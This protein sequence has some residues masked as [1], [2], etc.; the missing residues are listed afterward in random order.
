MPCSTSLSIANRRTDL[1][2]GAIA[3]LKAFVANER[4]LQRMQLIAFRQTFDGRDFTAVVNH[5]QRQTGVDTPAVDEHGAGATLTVIAAFLCAGQI[6]L[7]AQQVESDT[8]GSR[9]KP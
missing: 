1:T 6:E 9:R 7:F 4:R 2:R 3:T 8:R 5:R